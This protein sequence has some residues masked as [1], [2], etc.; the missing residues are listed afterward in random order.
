MTQFGCDIQFRQQSG[1]D[2][3]TMCV[4][5]AKFLF[6][7]KEIDSTKLSSGTQKIFNEAR[8]TSQLKFLVLSR[9]QIFHSILFLATKYPFR[10]P[11]HTILQ[12]YAFSVR[13]MLATQFNTSADDDQKSI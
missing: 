11:S 12:D 5:V 3:L 9:D 10:V 7:E 2:G 4:S 8:H 13:K 1:P 6:Q